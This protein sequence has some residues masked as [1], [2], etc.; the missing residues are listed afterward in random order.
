VLSVLEPIPPIAA[1]YGVVLPPLE[2]DG[3]RKEGLLDVVKKQIE[4]V[5]G[6]GADWDIE[7]RDGDPRDVIARMARDIGA[8]MTIVG[9]G[10]HEVLDRLFGSETALRALRVAREPVLAVPAD[11]DHLPARAVIATDFSPG[12]V[13]AARIALELFD[14]LT[15]VYLVHVAPR[16]ELQPEAFAA[17][18]SL[19]GEGVVPAFERVK[20]EIG[21]PPNVKVETVTLE[22]KPSRAILQLARAM[23][24]D[25]IVTGSRG[26]GFID[27]LLVGSTATGLIRGA[28][29]SVLAV[30]APAV[31]SRIAKAD[32]G[33]KISVPEKKW[34]TE[35]DAFTKRNAGR[36]AALEVDD[37]EFGAQ[38]QEHDYPFLGVAYDHHDRRVEIMVGDFEGVFRHLTRSIADVTSIDVLRDEHGRDSI[39]R[40][41]HGDA[42][43]ILT[44]G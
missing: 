23:N 19:Y 43:T 30:P 31:V 39:L 5:V 28:H 40:I 1:D 34:T 13:R 36:R 18:M 12:S 44:L 17:W 26:A 42:Q 10:R 22:G 16:L 11:Y 27:R 3:L 14:S 33:E 6:R 4:S 9:I 2:N 35:L 41:A 7:I 32:E 21:F 15:V 38:R 25:L 24:A 8:R 20:A 29:C 37:P